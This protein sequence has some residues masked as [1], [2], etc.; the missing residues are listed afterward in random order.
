LRQEIRNATLL[1]GLLIVIASA[2]CEDDGRELPVSGKEQEL[3]E[4]ARAG[5]YA[6]AADALYRVRGAELEAVA[7]LPGAAVV[8]SDTLEV[9]GSEAPEFGEA[10]FRRLT[11]SPDTA[12]AAWETAGPGAC[13]GVV[14]IGEP[15]VRVLGR[16]SAAVP[17]TLIWAPA[18]RYLAVWLAQG[19]RRRSLE[20]FDAREGERLEMPWELDCSYAEVCDVARATWLGGTLLNVEIRLGPAELSVP[21]E[22]NVDAAAPV[23]PREEL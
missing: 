18:G 5:P 2:G 20:V 3:S 8:A 1:A 22:V 6:I 9:C 14:G 15:P 23:E 19:A 10:R 13:V 16:W 17:D 4:P 21:F 11:L 12:L 7:V